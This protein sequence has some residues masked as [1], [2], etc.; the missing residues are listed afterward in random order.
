MLRSLRHGDVGPDVRAI[1]EGLNK[2]L[3]D[4]FLDPDGKFGTNTEKAVRLF[5]HRK[6]LVVD[7]VVGPRTRSVLFPLVATTITMMGLRLPRVGEA[8]RQQF[9]LSPTQNPSLTPLIL[10]PLTLP[11]PAP[12]P[13]ILPVP[14]LKF[15]QFQL[16]PG[17][18]VSFTNLFRDPQSSWAFT[19]QSIFKRGEDD[20]RQ[21]LALG[22]QLGAPIFVAEQGS[23][24]VSVSW[25]VN[26]TWVD[27]L[28][29]LGQFHLWSPFAT[30]GGQSD[31]NSGV[32]TVGVGLFPI[33]F[34]IDL[35]KD[36]LSFQVNNGVV[37][38][39]GVNSRQL[40]WS[41]QTT[42]GL[43]GTLTLF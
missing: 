6:G 34:G 23:P 24:S 15:D 1:Q 8:P 29:S 16:Q 35:E 5:Q 32:S 10:P 19:F 4:V 31:L 26:Y 36:R 40:T 18:Q 42:F 27:P 22:M 39:Y 9:A 33:N 38:T 21:E 43:A 20:G 3:F 28:G 13:P 25:F 41:V 14:K 12:S 37:G 17:N 7:G 2:A 11:V 30:V